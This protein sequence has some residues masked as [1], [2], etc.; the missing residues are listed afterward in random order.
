MASRAARWL[1]LA[2]VRFGAFR[3]GLSL[4]KGGDVAAGQGHPG[5]NLVPSRSVIVTRSGAILPKP[6][7]V[8]VGLEAGRRGRGQSCG[9]VRGSTLIDRRKG[10]SHD[11]LRSEGGS[12][13]KFCANALLISLTIRR[14]VGLD[15]GVE[16]GAGGPKRG[17]KSCEGRHFAS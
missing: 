4:R 10:Q 8:S 3:S 5:R 11:R 2:P 16:L 6:V 12:R 9:S 1:A 13:T 14:W 7:K 17:G 15:P